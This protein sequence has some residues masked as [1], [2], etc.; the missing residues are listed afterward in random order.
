MEQPPAISS[1]GQR[2]FYPSDFLLSS[3]DN[4]LHL[5]FP[6]RDLVVQL[7]FIRA[8]M[9]AYAKSVTQKLLLGIALVVMFS[10]VPA[11]ADFF[12]LE[13]KFSDPDPDPI[14][15]DRFGHSVGLSESYGIVGATRYN[16][17][18]K[19]SGV[20]YLFDLESDQNLFK[21][22]AS[23]TTGRDNFGGEVAVSNET[24]LIGASRHNSDA[25]SA[26]IFDNRT[27]KQLYKL[28]GD[29]PNKRAHFGSGVALYEN[30]AVVGAPTDDGEINRSGTAY[31]FDTSTGKQTGK[32]MA[33]DASTRSGFGVSVAIDEENVI[34][35]APSDNRIGAA[36]L[37]DLAT[38][39]E[40]T[41]LTAS[42]AAD[43]DSFGGSVSISGNLAIIGAA[44]ADEDGIDSGAAYI[45]DISTGEE[46]FKLTAS[47]AAARDRFGFS[48]A[49]HGDLA[50]VG[51]AL[52]RHVDGLSLGAAYVFDA[53]TGEELAR[54]TPAGSGWFGI[55]VALRN[56]HAFVGASGNNSAY[57]F[58]SVPEPSTLLM[59][60]VVGIGYLMLRRTSQTRRQIFL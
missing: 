34:V 4:Y 53:N 38:S 2:S 17:A 32:L 51:S 42:D 47:D 40:L 22:Q 52:N 23:D 58:A 35:G 45:F 39:N 41:K 7:S 6:N 49:I 21:F 9:T 11:F 19:S 43:S 57:L 10:G 8:S 25:G 27:G 59:Q 16:D 44:L 33:S 1:T 18:G 60:T 31:L 48:V 56:N 14:L 15:F 36:Y 3:I 29:H 46:L 37:F 12:D 13:T 54:L 50:I 24:S 5:H 26:Y 55:S 20:A 28:S 30:T